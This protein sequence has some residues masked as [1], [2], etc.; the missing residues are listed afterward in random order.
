[1]MKYESLEEKSNERIDPRYR[2]ISL[3]YDYFSLYEMAKALELDSYERRKN[4]III[5]LKYQ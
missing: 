3:L 1:M 2:A 5:S 4:E